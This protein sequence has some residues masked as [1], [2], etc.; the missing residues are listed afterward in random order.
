MNSN[1]FI[2]QTGMR[3]IIWTWRKRNCM[4]VIKLSYGWLQL[5]IMFINLDS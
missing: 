4:L 2:V 3:V 1:G 5:L